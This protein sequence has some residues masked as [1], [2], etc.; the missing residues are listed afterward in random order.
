MGSWT[1]TGRQEHPAMMRSFEFS[2]HTRSPAKGEVRH[3]LN[4]PADHASVM[5]LYKN[6]S[7]SGVQRACRLD[8]GVL[9]ERCPWRRRGRSTPHAVHF[10]LRIFL[11]PLD[12][13]L[14]PSS[15][16]FLTDL[17]KSGKAVLLS[18]ERHS[19]K[20]LQPNEGVLGISHV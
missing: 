3:G 14:C 13:R 1:G 9:G 5:N 12:T 11:F 15:C 8:T 18:S 20:S 7:L 17:P 16:P 2:P 6:V 4:N 19:S 10:V